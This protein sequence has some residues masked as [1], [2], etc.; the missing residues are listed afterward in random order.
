LRHIDDLVL[1]DLN[2]GSPARLYALH[3]AMS[4]TAVED[5]TATVQERFGYDG[6]GQP[7]FMT[8][9]F[10]SR[11]SSSYGWEV[12][13]DAYR[14]DQECGFYQVRNRYLH[15]ELGRWLRRDPLGEL[16][17]EITLHR[18][19]SEDP[20]QQAG[21]QDLYAFVRNRPTER[22]DVYGLMDSIT[23]SVLGCI[24]AGNG[25]AFC[26]CQ[27]A[28]DSDEC[29]SGLGACLDALG[30]GL[31]NPG[32]GA[33]G[34]LPTALEWC[35]CGCEGV[36]QGNQDAIDKC[37][38]GCDAACSLSKKLPLPKSPKPPKPSPPPRRPKPSGPPPPDQPWPDP[39]P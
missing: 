22:V 34:R 23:L 21:G 20:A 13:F 10:G 39:A 9:G 27:I 5:T 3:D 36:N 19:L 25:F 18:W 6:F 35:K 2:G 17:F 4:V 7:R 16:G 26:I 8:S 12:L 14:W 30:A 24:R 1:R 37:K 38:K 28:P 11:T 15:P 31:P 32:T 29:E 33:P